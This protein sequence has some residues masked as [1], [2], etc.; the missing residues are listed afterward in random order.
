MSREIT[1]GGAVSAITA[2]ANQ[3]EIRGMVLL[4]PA[5]ILSERANEMYKNVED[6][7]DTSFFLWMDVGRAYFEPLIGYDIYEEISAYEDDVLLIHGDAD[8]IVPLSYSERALEVYKS[9][10][11]KVISGGGH[12]FYGE[13]AQKT[14]D[15]M[16][17][18]LD[19]KVVNTD[20]KA[21]SVRE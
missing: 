15:Y 18:Y 12:G 4:Y 20:E 5:F 7:P 17:E 19:K 10:E 13:D 2:A 8:N 16:L 14:I 9:A 21:S 11:L 1:E 6:I 3:E